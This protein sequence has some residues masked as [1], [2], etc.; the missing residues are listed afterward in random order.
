MLFVRRLQRDQ[1]SE[2]LKESEFLFRSQ[3]DLGNIGIAITHPKKNWLRVNPRLCEMLGYSE[4][5]LL[6]L[7][8]PELSHPR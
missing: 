5:K 7:T 6:H 1:T 4:D 2:A 3:F 8:W